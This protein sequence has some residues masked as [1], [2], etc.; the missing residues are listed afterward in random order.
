PYGAAFQIDELK[1][2]NPDNDPDARYNRSAVPLAKRWMG[3]SV[4][5]NASR[6]ARIIPLSVA[7]ARA[8]Q[9]PSQGGDGSYIYTPTNF[10]YVD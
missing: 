3:P 2:W 1:N 6:D 9:A 4:N 8:S 5:P 7:N 10:Q